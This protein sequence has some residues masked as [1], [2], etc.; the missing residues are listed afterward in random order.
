MVVPQ[1]PAES[2][3]TED[4][5]VVLTDL[6]PWLDQTIL[7]ALVVS[8]LV[9]VL[10][11]SVDPMLLHDVGYRARRDAVSKVRQGALD[12]IVSPGRILAGHAQHE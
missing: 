9:I 4:L 5:T 8:F 1:Y 10:A 3:S 11:E 12:A 7:Q 6:F 2:L